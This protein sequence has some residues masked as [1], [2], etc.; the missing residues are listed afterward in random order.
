MKKTNLEIRPV[1]FARF[2]FT[3]FA[4]IPTRKKDS[5]RSLLTI[6][7]NFYTICSD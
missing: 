3:V 6:L 7:I 5:K 4:H 2:I 1:D